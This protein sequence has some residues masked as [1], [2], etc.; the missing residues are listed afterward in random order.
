[1]GLDGAFFAIPAARLAAFRLNRTSCR[2]IWTVT[3]RQGAP[4]AGTG[5]TRS[6]RFGEA[7]A[8]RAAGV[9]ALRFGGGKG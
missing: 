4:T 1:M 3:G 6:P 9:I 8:G 5:R 7:P 2:P